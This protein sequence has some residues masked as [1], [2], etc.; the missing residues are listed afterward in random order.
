MTVRRS[1]LRAARWSALLVIAIVVWRATALAAPPNVLVICADDHAAYAIG[2]YGNT[3]AHTPNIDRLA[4][5][6]LRFDRAYCNSPVC[7]ASRQ[8]FLTGC[9]PRSLGVTR[10][11][12]PLPEEALTLAEI[13]AGAGYDTASFGK[14]HFNSNLHHGFT[15]RLDAPEH[16]HWL[17][18]QPAE[19]PI[20]RAVLPNWKPFQDPARVWLNSQCLPYGARDDRMQGTWLAR[21]AAEWLNSR[22]ERPFFLVVSFYE[23]H[24]PFRF[25]VEFADR[26]SPHE[27]ATPAVT[28]DDRP[29]IPACF[30]D[31]TD[32]EKRGIAAAYYTS[33]EFL[34]KN[35][36]LVCDALEESG[37]AENTL[38][39]YL[40]DHGYLLGQ[41][42][43]FEKHCSYEEAIRAPLL[44]RAPG[45]S[46]GVTS[47]LVELIDVAPTI[48]SRCELPVPAAMQGR[49]LDEILAGQADRHRDHVFVEYAP[50]EEIAVRDERYKLVYIAGLHERDDG[51]KTGAPPAGR[52]IRL[53][54]LHDDPHEV[55]NLAD[56]PEQRALIDKYLAMLA[57]HL[58]ATAREP[59]KIPTGELLETLDFCVQ[60]RDVEPS[61]PVK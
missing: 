33:V 5:S 23:P 49:P 60:S 44:I 14:M 8:S 3:L 41:H 58:R 10:L 16:Q 50:N 38:V 21:R 55:V 59:D 56:R 54:D 48:L 4:H 6:S 9:Y 52:E 35:V 20:T 45:N 22:G 37:H 32:D 47:A 53:F 15:E 27:F 12:T 30:A 36:G 34:D 25:P 26:R 11:S 43:R 29:R 19:E 17:K 2:A 42:G 61:A 39:V 18:D 57:G 24:S 31:L 1:S 51:Y 13:L 40:G 28:D 46:P 7:T